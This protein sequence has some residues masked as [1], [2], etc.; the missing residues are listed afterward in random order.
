M[1]APEDLGFSE[2]IAKLISETFTAVTEAALEQERRYAQ[3]AAA[4]ALSLEEFL[5][6]RGLDLVK[7]P[8]MTDDPDEGDYYIVS[9]RML[10][11]TT[12]SPQREHLCW[13][14][15]IKDGSREGCCIE[16]WKDGEDFVE[17]IMEERA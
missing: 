2:F 12:P 17:K 13:D 7:V 16:K 6:K 11:S 15:T 3:L 1:P 4:A 8:S 14:G 9:P 5:D 10:G